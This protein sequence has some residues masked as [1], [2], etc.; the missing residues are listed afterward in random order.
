MKL[1]EILAVIQGDHTKVTESAELHLGS[2]PLL[3]SANDTLTK[4]VQ[5]A[6]IDT[7]DSE[8]AKRLSEMLKQEQLFELIGKWPPDGTTSGGTPSGSA[9]PTKV[10]RHCG[11][12]NP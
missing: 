8:L 2:S 12:L 4:L 3:R 1:N 11:Q 10:C 9:V 5:R 7:P 6:L